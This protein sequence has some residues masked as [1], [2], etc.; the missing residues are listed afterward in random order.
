VG[1]PRPRSFSAMAPVIYSVA[2]S[3]R[4]RTRGTARSGSLE[5]VSAVARLP[6]GAERSRGAAVSQRVWLGLGD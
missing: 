6:I 2:D 5:L 3:P 4:R 1:R